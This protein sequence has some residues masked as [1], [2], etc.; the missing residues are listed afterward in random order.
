[1][2][3][4][5]MW[6]EKIYIIAH[7]TEEGRFDF[8]TSGR[9]WDGFVYFLQGEGYYIGK[10]GVR[11]NVDGGDMVLVR[12]GQSYG[13]SFENGCEYV[14]TA[15]DIGED[16]DSAG[17]SL[18]EMDTVSRGKH[19]LRGAVLSLCRLWN[20]DVGDKKVRARATILEIF[21]RLRHDLDSKYD[22][23]VEKAI[24]YIH[25]KYREHF[26]SEDLS[27]YCSVSESYLRTKFRKATGMSVTAYRES[28]RITEAKYMLESGFF[29]IAEI[30]HFLGYSDVYHFSKRFAEAVGVPPGKYKK[31]FHTKK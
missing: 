13:F 5:D 19:E 24:E 9:Q 31:S 15:F 30:A 11:T 21:D 10:D 12:R 16:A 1:M 28:L 18:Y 17:A 6:I 27:R 29:D 4:R 3:T 14:T 8:Y 25:Q 22:K 7:K 23:D 26:S 2:I 20:E